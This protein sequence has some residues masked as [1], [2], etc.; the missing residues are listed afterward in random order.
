[1][2]VMTHD[3][4]PSGEGS[5]RPITAI[6][7][8]AQLLHCVSR[9]IQRGEGVSESGDPIAQAFRP[10]LP[11]MLSAIAS[12][13]GHTPEVAYPI[14]SPLHIGPTLLEAFPTHPFSTN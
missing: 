1:M 12:K 13:G 4:I 5:I 2:C 7:C 8:I 9:Q 6:R 14:V 3:R 10:V 11:L